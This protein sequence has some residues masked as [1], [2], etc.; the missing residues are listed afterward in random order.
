MHDLIP[1]CLKIFIVRPD[2]ARACRKSPSEGGGPGIKRFPNRSSIQPGEWERSRGPEGHK[3]NRHNM[4]GILY[5][6]T[7]FPRSPSPPPL[8][9]ISCILYVFPCWCCFLSPEECQI[10][11]VA[12]ALC[13]VRGALSGRVWPPQAEAV[14]EVASR[15]MHLAPRSSRHRPASGCGRNLN[16]NDVRMAK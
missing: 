8:S 7:C 11:V 2:S 1:A 3:T 16:K 5:F 15:R 14:E 4:L 12:C 6:H 13:V 10:S 9:R